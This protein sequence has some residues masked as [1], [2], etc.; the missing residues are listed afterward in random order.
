M[1]KCNLTILQDIPRITISGFS[2]R[3]TNPIIH[4][5]FGFT[6]APFMGRLDMFSDDGIRGDNI[7]QDSK[8]QIRIDL[9]MEQVA[10]TGFLMQ[11]SRPVTWLEWNIWERV[12]NVA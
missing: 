1:R 5:T 6:H 3:C 12:S 11:M 2:R 10:M 9:S 4:H 7:Y 8:F